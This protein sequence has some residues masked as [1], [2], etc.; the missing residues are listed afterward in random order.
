MNDRVRTGWFVAGLLAAM[1]LGGLVM[2]MVIAAD[3]PEQDP[4]AATPAPAPTGFRSQ[5]QPLA[6]PPGVERPRIPRERPEEARITPDDRRAMN[7]AVDDVLKAARADCLEP[8]VGTVSP[9]VA[10]EVVFDAVLIDGRVVDI[11]IRALTHEIPPDVLACVADRAWL[12]DWPEWELK[13]E[14]RMQRSFEVSG[15]R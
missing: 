7:F 3:V 11:G 2:V 6:P 4:A 10:E 5:R 8:W 13:G 14:L 9:E 15:R 1:L 12:S